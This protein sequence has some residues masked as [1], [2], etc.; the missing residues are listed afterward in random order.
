MIKRNSGILVGAVISPLLLGLSCSP[1]PD[2]EVKTAQS[3]LLVPGTLQI[4][5]TSVTVGDSP[6]FPVNVTLAFANLAPPA[7]FSSPVNLGSCD[8]TFGCSGLHPP[9]TP[10]TKSFSSLGQA[11]AFGGLLHV[12]SQNL[13]G[14][15]AGCFNF[16]FNTTTNKV[17]GLPHNASNCLGE[18]GD[19]TGNTVSCTGSSC[20]ASIFLLG[21]S[22]TSN[23]H[24]S[25]VNFTYKVVPPANTGTAIVTPSYMI[26]NVYYAP[27]GQASN[28]NYQSTTS[29]GTTTSI[30]KSFQSSETLTAD[31]KTTDKV[32]GGSA[33][34]QITA[35]NTWGTTQTDEKDLEVDVTN[36]YTINGQVDGVDHNDDEIWLLLSPQLRVNYSQPLDLSLP[37]SMTWSY[38]QNQDG[39]NNA[40]PAKVLVRWL[41]GTTQMNVN[42]AEAL[43][44]HGVTTN[45]YPSILA[46]DP[47]ATGSPNPLVYPNRYVAIG[48]FN[49]EPA[50]GT[51]PNPSTTELKQA[52]G[53]SS[54]AVATQSYS[55]GMSVSGG[56]DF[57]AGI[58]NAKLTEQKTLTWTNSSSNKMSN[59]TIIDDKLTTT[60]PPSTYL[61]PIFGTIYEDTIYKTYAFNLFPACGGGG[62]AAQLCNNPGGTP[63]SECVATRWLFESG[64]PPAW[65]NSEETL[66]GITTKQAHSG[67][68]SLIVSAS[69]DPALPASVNA[70]QCFS[71]AGGGT[72]N[73]AGKTY[74][75]WVLVPNSTSSYAGTNCRLRAFDQSFHEATLTS[76]ALRAPIPPGA[77]FQLSGVFPS[78]ATNIYEL[79][80]ECKL[81]TNW[82]FDSTLTSSVWYVDD[83]T[84]N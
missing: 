34:V 74:S 41:N 70:E 54:T 35:N 44:A 69:S 33:S 64:E 25:H 30:T 13:S 7:N 36:G 16:G 58:F 15:L 82:V 14:T 80:V 47:L 26:T 32:T 3:A 51:R 77:W 9:T 37:G 19:S 50:G 49:F 23:P 24:P 27:P 84:V 46:A 75:A 78:T 52:M 63:A 55:V 2:P 43:A 45:D 4:T 57:D 73:L 12:Q 29:I 59:G 48:S 38:V 53:S 31:G 5:V 62:S 66:S 81:P 39:Q 65:N 10:W 1:Q 72:M 83:V 76:G 79:T 40:I 22:R 8:T 56:V 21:N 71:A 42:V 28:V 17:T 67:T 6:S 18:I 11:L 20:S 61:G 60:A 68:Q